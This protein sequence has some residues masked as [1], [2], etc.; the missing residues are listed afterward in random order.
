V[1]ISFGWLIIS[2]QALW[3]GVVYHRFYNCELH[4]LKER[5]VIRV[6]RSYALVG[7][8]DLLLVTLSWLVN[9]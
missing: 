4:F 8:S 9:S 1:L 3:N 5:F 6:K 7:A 2:A